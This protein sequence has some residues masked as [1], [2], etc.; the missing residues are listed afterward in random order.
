MS[1]K[2]SSSILFGQARCHKS[3]VVENIFQRHVHYQVEPYV[4]AD[5]RKVRT[6]RSH[7]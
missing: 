3:E 7:R 6:H 1:L 2:W 5:R 4:V